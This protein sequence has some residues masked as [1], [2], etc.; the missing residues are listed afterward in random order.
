MKVPHLEL[1]KEPTSTPPAHPLRTLFH[2]LRDFESQLVTAS[3]A[4]DFEALGAVRFERDVELML[5]YLGTLQANLLEV[6]ER[7]GLIGWR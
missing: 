5:E 7:N 4:L 6:A 1:V 3:V 2:Q